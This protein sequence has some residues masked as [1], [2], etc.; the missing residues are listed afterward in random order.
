MPVPRA[1]LHLCHPQ[2]AS[3]GQDSRDTSFLY[4]ALTVQHQASRSVHL[5]CVRP[6]FSQS[7]SDSAASPLQLV[8]PV[9]RLGSVAWSTMRMASSKTS[10]LS[11]CQT[12]KLSA[13]VLVCTDLQASCFICMRLLKE[14]YMR[15]ELFALAMQVL[16]SLL[17]A[18][19]T[20]L[21]IAFLSLRLVE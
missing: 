13:R 6:A 8:L 7:L 9:S 15:V 1:V 4:I 16:C 11:E 20:S 5:T 21:Q 3:L 12:S 19:K 17:V 14:L 2:I 18:C 10:A